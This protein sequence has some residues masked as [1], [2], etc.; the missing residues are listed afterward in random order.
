MRE[1]K[2]DAVRPP[3][4]SELVKVAQSVYECLNTPVSL[5]CYMQ[6]KYGELK[7]LVSRTINPA[8]YCDPQTFDDDY[9]AVSLLKKA[10]FLDTGIDRRGAAIAK[11]HEAEQMCSATN[12]RLQ[13]YS[14]SRL[15]P[16]DARIHGVLHRA[17][18]L[19]L[20]VLGQTPK[21]EKAWRDLPESAGRHV[22]GYLAELPLQ[23]RFGPGATSLVQRRI[24]LAQKYRRHVDASPRLM[25][26]LLDVVGPQWLRHIESVTPVASNRVT[27]VPKDAKTDRSIA[28]EPH[29]NIYAQLGVASLIR[30]QMKRVVGIDLENQAEWNRW[31]ASRAHAWRLATIDL[32][33][34]SD[35][36]S[37]E[38][39]W[40]LL[41]EAWADLLDLVRSPYGTLN[42]VE[43]EYQKF[44]SMGNGCT[45]ELETLI[46]YALARACGSHRAL[47]S[48][49]G[50]DIIVEAE[51]AE[52]LVETLEF[53]GF[54]VNMDKSFFAGSFYESCGQDYFEGRN[55]RPVFW[56]DLD[57]P[58]LFKASNDISRIALRRGGGVYRDK[59][60]LPA[61]IRSR[62]LAEKRGLGSCLVPDG[63][64]DIGC[65]SSFDA[66]CPPRAKNGWDGWV[67]NTLKF[68]PKLSLV[69]GHEGAWL[70]S[71]DGYSTE[72]PGLPGHSRD[73]YHTIRG[74]GT[75]RK[76]RLIALGQWRDHGPWE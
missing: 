28:V 2:P 41:P 42:G 76:T 36:L 3:T 73:G 45:F 54:R 18:E 12:Q 69:N 50:D 57:V 16:R 61:W 52:L 20:R 58:L 13:A 23:M 65:V 72:R 68:L 75:W 9:Q 14:E 74:E 38:L 27:F 8:H 43:F 34:A 6:L 29:L 66:V 33:M 48:A 31:L 35:T 7:D 64:G 32:S 22:S 53:C 51:V 11:F 70:A 46:F 39:V 25:T 10:A 62:K 37:R 15:M 19:I 40:L 56:K 5:G 1:H 71:L 47:T 30:R 24:T 59:R 21:A 63:F 17:R 55:V 60:F 67:V 4:G 26:R 44:S 49:F